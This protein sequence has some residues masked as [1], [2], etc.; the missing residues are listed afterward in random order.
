MILEVA[1]TPNATLVWAPTAQDADRLRLELTAAGH[2]ALDADPVD[3]DILL[4]A[5]GE[6]APPGLERAFN[7]KMTAVARGALTSLVDA[8]HDLTWHWLQ[9][10]PPR[11][12]WGVTVRVRH[13][14]RADPEPSFAAIP[15]PLASVRRATAQA[16][17]RPL[18]ARYEPVESAVHFGVKVRGSRALGLHLSRETYARINKRSSMSRSVREDDPGRWDAMDRFYEDTEHRISPTNGARRSASP[19]W[20]TTT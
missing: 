18:R 12:A 10:R 15:P 19:R 14:S 9:R 17:G 13:A 8:G 3:L 5:A 16:A 1:T 7:V 20:R 6:A 2:A 4:R 11:K